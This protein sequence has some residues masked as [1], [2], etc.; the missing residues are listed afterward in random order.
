MFYVG[1]FSI[2][3]VNS[4]SSENIYKSIAELAEPTPETTII[5]LCSGT[6]GIAF[7][8]AKVSVSL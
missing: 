4:S 6:G 5:D 3:N 7:T 2:L 8:I 1:P